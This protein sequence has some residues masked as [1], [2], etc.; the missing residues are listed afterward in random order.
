MPIICLLWVLFANAA[1][2]DFDLSLSELDCPSI[3]ESSKV[4]N[5][6]TPT[7]RTLW[8]LVWSCFSIIFLCTWAAVH[9][10]VPNPKDCHWTIRLRRMKMCLIAV[11]AP[12]WMVMWALRQLIQAIKL[13]NRYNESLRIPK[14]KWIVRFLPSGW[15]PAL[16]DFGNASK[17][18]D[19][20]D[21]EWDQKMDE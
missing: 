10:N 19:A 11:I 14:E 21:S 18:H 7:T 6:T 12:E 16:R 8:S 5:L 20:S 1:S 2:L 15:K 9:P 4:N 17:K 3:N 13:R